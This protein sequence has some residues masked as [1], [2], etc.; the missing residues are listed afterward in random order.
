MLFHKYPQNLWALSI[1]RQ[2]KKILPELGKDS[3]IT[4]APCGNAIIA[5]FVKKEFKDRTVIALDNDQKLMN[6][7]YILSKDIS[8]K[9]R[10]EDI[11]NHKIEG[12]DNVWLLI[13]SLFCLPE[14]ERLLSCTREQ[15]KFIIAIIPDI[16]AGNFIFFQNRNP[17]FRNPSAMKVGETIN[18]FKTNGYSLKYRE[19]LTSVQFHKFNKWFE[20][21]RVPIAIRNLLLTVLDYLFF[22]KKKQYVLLTFSRYETNNTLI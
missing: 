5:Y 1:N 6:S 8:L 16:E 18:F 14:K 22:F 21:M 20:S 17:E 11:Y 15:Y 9:I 19:D 10:L 13:N 7:R 2:L 4:D 3:T 12:K